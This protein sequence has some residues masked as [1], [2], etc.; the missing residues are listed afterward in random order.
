MY[1]LGRKDARGRVGRARNAR[2]AARRSLPLAVLAVGASLPVRADVID[3]PFFRAGPVVVVFGA[4]DYLENGG[5]APVVG[6]F[7][8][9][10]DA[11][12]GGSGQ[13]GVDLIT[14]DLRPI[15]YN[16][17]RFN[18]INNPENAGLEYTVRNATFGG[19]FNSSGPHQTLDANDSYDLF[20]I[21]NDTDIVRQ[22]A[23]GR[24]SRF[25]VASNAPFDIFARASNLTSTGAF[26]ALGYEN[27]RFRLRVQPTGGG[28]ANRW[29]GRAQDPSVGGDGIVLGQFTGPLTTLDDLAQPDP[30][31]VFDGGRR[32]ATGPGSIL[33]QAVSFQARYNLRQAGALTSAANFDFSLGTGTLAAEV[34]YTVYSP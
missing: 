27:I 14:G 30:V 31:K 18:P 9:L 33:D 3:Q 21:D 15:N 13:P 16:S 1:P 28:G 26:S 24:A 19:A 4:S 22:G 12:T 34:T 5:V 8:L 29:G 25:F 7:L 6:D 11:T 2:S 20:G 23:G 10:D 32:T 17:Q